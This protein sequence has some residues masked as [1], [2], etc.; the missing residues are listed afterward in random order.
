MRVYI[1]ARFSR[2]HEVAACAGDLE[3]RGIEVTSRWFRGGHEWDGSPD[4]DIPVERLSRFAQE[5]L[6][7]LVAADV[8]VCLTE[9][10]RSGP[11]R[12]GRHVEFGYALARQMPVLTVGYREN[13][14]YCLP[15]VQYAES[16]EAAL[17][18][19]SLAARL[20]RRTG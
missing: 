5:D 10:P 16:W 15:A 13:V 4:E 3:A 14:F 8:L 17:D 19:L 18:A 6:D 1:A 12:G 7:D 20:M 2:Q 11:S 9:S